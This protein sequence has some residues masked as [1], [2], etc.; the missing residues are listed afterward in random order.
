M[1]PAGRLWFLCAGAEDKE[2]STF[3]PP[4]DQRTVGDVPKDAPIPLAGDIMSTALIR[5]INRIFI[6]CLHI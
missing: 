4:V 3:C 2:T 6:L 1:T 5:T